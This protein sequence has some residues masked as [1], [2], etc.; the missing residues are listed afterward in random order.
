VEADSALIS[1]SLY[2]LGL[3]ALQAMPNFG[4]LTLR[5]TE[6]GGYA[7]IEVEDTGA[8]IPDDVL[9]KLFKPFFSTKASGTG[10]GLAFTQKVVL[11]HGGR[12]EAFN[13]K[14]DGYIPAGGAIFRIELP[15]V[16]GNA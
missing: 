2:N 7:R 12:I 13:R 1:N 9:P 8:G 14:A 15:L 6:L 4:T 3:N 16:K 5:L 10:L 11:A